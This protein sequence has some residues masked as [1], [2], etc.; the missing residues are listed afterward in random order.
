LI[1]QKIGARIGN[2]NVVLYALGN[3]PAFF[4]TTSTSVFHDI[5]TGNNSDPC[6]G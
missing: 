6:T 4:N 3:N 2:A 5:T 1:E